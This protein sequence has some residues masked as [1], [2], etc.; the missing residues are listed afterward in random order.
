MNDLATL[1]LPEFRRKAN[2]MQQARSEA[3][4]DYARYAE[5]EADQ[6]RLYR[7]TLAQAFAKAKSGDATA[8]QAELQAHADAADFKHARDLAKAMAKA[9]LLRIESLEA[10]RA[11][12]R[13]VAEWSQKVDATGAGQVA[14]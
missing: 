10:D 2:A 1:T 12:L 6:D 9:A 7:Q 3:R 14:G 11:T 4:R 13:S 5:Q 8:A